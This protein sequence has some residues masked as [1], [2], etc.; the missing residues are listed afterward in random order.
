MQANSFLGGLPDW[1]VSDRPPGVVAEHGGP[2]QGSLLT[3]EADE[4]ALTLSLNCP[5]FKLSRTLVLRFE[6]EGGRKIATAVKASIGRFVGELQASNLIA[7]EHH[8]QVSAKHS[9]LVDGVLGKVLDRW[10][11]RLQRCEEIEKEKQEWCQKVTRIRTDYIR[12]IEL[13]RSKLRAVE[14]NTPVRDMREHAMPQNAEMEV[15]TE[16]AGQLGENLHLWAKCLELHKLLDTSQEQLA[17]VR[18]KL[19]AE[20]EYQIEMRET[21]RMQNEL[22]KEIQ[23]QVVEIEAELRQVRLA[24]AKE[25][26]DREQFGR[27]LV[28]VFEV[29]VQA[30]AWREQALTELLEFATR[31]PADR[32]PDNLPAR[33][34]VAELRQKLS[35]FSADTLHHLRAAAVEFQQAPQ[36]LMFGAVTSEVEAK[37]GGTLRVLRGL[38]NSQLWNSRGAPQEGQLHKFPWRAPDPRLQ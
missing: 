8:S 13:L 3:E 33:V 2:D 36:R 27:A 21:F 28:D 6:R 25:R 37:L 14:Q 20:R 9:A 35:S 7:N 4:S 10:N 31:V 34:V 11:D 32:S 12:E 16:M 29:L 5:A 24:A 23:E 38:L 15:Q 30:A 22:H 26:R 19:N 17:D 1:W 18:E